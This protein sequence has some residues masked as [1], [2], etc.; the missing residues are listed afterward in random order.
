MSEL[1]Q[2]MTQTHEPVAYLSGSPQSFEYRVQKLLIDNSGF[3]EG[4]FFLNNWLSLNNWIN[5]KSIRKFK[6]EELVDLAIRSDLPFL[7]IGDDEQ[8]DPEVY[9]D[10]QRKYPAQRTVEIYIHRVKGRTLPE[11]VIPFTSAFDIALH[12]Y[13]KGRLSLTSV[14]RVGHAVMTQGGEDRLFPSFKVCP[15]VFSSILGPHALTDHTLGELTQKIDYYI[16]EFCN[17]ATH[18]FE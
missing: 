16:Q 13:E 12:E 18:R 6:S 3:P 5:W 8:V 4:E 1:Y 7:M 15:K 14:M 9:L 2:E 17:L 11:G 10:F